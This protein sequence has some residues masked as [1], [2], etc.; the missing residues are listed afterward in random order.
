MK[1]TKGGDMKFRTTIKTAGKTATGIEV[2]E[3]VVQA[4]GS[5]RR[6]AVRVTINDY[7]YRST[8]ATMGGKFM[9]AVSADTREKAGV[10]GGDKVEVVIE[11]DTEPRTVKVPKDF[12]AALKRDRK[13]KDEFDSLSYSHKRRHVEPIEAAKKPE[14]RQRRIEKAVL[15]LHEGRGR[16]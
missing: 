10:A 4:L 12:A 6:P 13:A 8:V 2:P 3:R 9:V 15:M 1:L 16:G 7:T 5:S 14:T 11:P